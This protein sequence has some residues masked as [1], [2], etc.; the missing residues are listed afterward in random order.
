M[1]SP[2]EQLALARFRPGFTLLYGQ[3]ADS[4]LQRLALL[5]GRYGLGPRDE[6]AVH[7]WTQRDAV[8]ITYGDMVQTPDAAPLEV[9]ARF[10]RQH[11]GDAITAVH[12]LPF[13]PY[14]SD[15]GFSVIH[16]RQVDPALGTWNHVQELGKSYRLM[17]DLVL[18]HVSRQSGW[19]RDFEAGV[20]PGRDYF[21]TADP[22]TDLTAVVRPRTHPLLTPVHTR[23]G[24]RHVWTTFSADQVDL[25]FANPDVF[26]EL[27][28]ILLF[29]VTQGARIIRMDAIAYLWKKPGTPCIHLPETHEVVKLFR[30]FLDVV[31]PDVVLITETNVPHAENV[32]YFGAGDEAHMV[33]QFSLP[34]LLLHGLLNESAE[35]LTAWAAALAPPPPGCTFL[36][37]TAS[38]DGIG[39]RPLHGLIPDAELQQLA[40]HVEQQGGRVSMKK[41]ADGTESPYELNITYFDAMGTGDPT[42]QKA[43]FLCSQTIMMA[44]QG[45][46][47]LYFQSL[48]AAPNDQAGVHRTGSARSINRHKWQE[49]ELASRLGD[50][51]NPTAQLMPEL[52]RR[53]RLRASRAA[54]DPAAAQII[55]HLDPHVFALERRGTND[56]VLA[57]HNL[58]GQVRRV[59]LPDADKDQSWRDLLDPELGV[60][61]GTEIELPPHGCRWLTPVVVEE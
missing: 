45:V 12:V 55:H 29:Y 27:L 15:D 6:R 47:A 53:L 8:L 41:N 19:F 34:P 5:A 35:R 42:R 1:N 44:L 21:V 28:D 51:A 32:S 37:F 58:S 60:H 59:R 25:D 56:R 11:V 26:F 48:V 50:P 18:N 14:S 39:V 31:A 4:C 40:R 10:L 9:L 17:V 30:A 7:G 52:L 13:F 33:Y 20:A 2:L 16:F 23:G 24:V 36:N 49:L 38:H 46:P 43:R 61:R 22:A 54:F 57:L 3:R